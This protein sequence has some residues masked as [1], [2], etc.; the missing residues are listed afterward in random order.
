MGWQTGFSYR[1]LSLSSA[2]LAK[3]YV[4]LDFH[5]VLGQKFARSEEKKQSPII[6]SMG[7]WQKAKLR[8]SYYGLDD[9]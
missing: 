7:C 6:A 4:H 3:I 2:S 9:C 1:Q 5:T 8:C